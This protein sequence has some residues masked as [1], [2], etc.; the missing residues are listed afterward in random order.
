[1]RQP[2][3]RRFK[4]GPEF[5]HDDSFIIPDYVFELRLSPQAFRVYAHL[6][7][8]HDNNWPDNGIK[9]TAKTCLMS[10][11]SVRRAMS[12]LMEAKL[13]EQVFA[14]SGEKAA[15]LIQAKTPQSDIGLVALCEWCRCNTAWLHAHHFPVSRSDGGTE[16]VDICPNCHAEFHALTRPRYQIREDALWEAVA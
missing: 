15:K 2:M 1:M 16:T 8:L 12:E 7:C 6:K 5:I 4:R 11:N 10:S 14:M 13:V 3:T 9:A